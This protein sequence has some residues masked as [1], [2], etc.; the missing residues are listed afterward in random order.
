MFFGTSNFGGGGITPSPAPPV[1][2]PANQRI[3]IKAFLDSAVAISAPGSEIIILK[4]EPTN[5]SNFPSASGSER[6][7]RCSDLQGTINIIL[8]L[9]LLIIW[10]IQGT[11]ILMLLLIVLIIHYG[12]LY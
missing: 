11:I 7:I 8:M 12:L 9:L 2:G 5:F 6:G 3:R 10:M 1:Y 4:P